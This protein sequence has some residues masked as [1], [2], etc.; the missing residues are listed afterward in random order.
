MAMAFFSLSELSFGWGLQLQQAIGQETG[1][2]V[3]GL[4]WSED[5]EIGK[6]REGTAVEILATSGQEFICF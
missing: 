6:S 2:I 5:N 1:E 3:G 4:W